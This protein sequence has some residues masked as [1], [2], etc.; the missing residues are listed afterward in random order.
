MAWTATRLGAASSEAELIARAM[1]ALEPVQGSPYGT[2]EC[3]A[4]GK[5][6]LHGETPD[7]PTEQPIRPAPRPGRQ[8][9]P[10]RHLSRVS[11]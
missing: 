8:G 10:H 1:E 4:G 7:F 6:D 3:H 2:T 11:H 5:L 9:E